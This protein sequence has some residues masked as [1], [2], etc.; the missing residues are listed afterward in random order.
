MNLGTLLHGSSRPASPTGRTIGTPRR[1]D[2]VT[3]VLFAGKRRKSFRDL[4]A[5][6][7]IRA[8]DRVLD[9]GCGTGYYAAC[10]PKR[11]GRGARSLVSTPHPR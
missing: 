9:V 6:A 11:L 2:F 10:S 8:G 5:K 3:A 7:G 1:Y 4:A